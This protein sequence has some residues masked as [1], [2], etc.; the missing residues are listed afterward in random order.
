MSAPSIRA[1]SA[2]RAPAGLRQTPAYVTYNVCVGDSNDPLADDPGGFIRTPARGWYSAYLLLAGW[3]SSS[4][5]QLGNFHDREA[6][7]LHVVEEGKARLG[8]QELCC[9]FWVFLGATHGFA[10][11]PTPGPARIT[12]VRIAD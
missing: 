5:W 11:I 12:D 6:G 3:E 4:Y 9:M 7:G 2:R 1:V 10:L 8:M